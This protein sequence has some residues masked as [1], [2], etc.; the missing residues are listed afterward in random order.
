[1][2]MLRRILRGPTVPMLLIMTAVVLMLALPAKPARACWNTV[3]QE[4]F[5]QVAGPNGYVW[6]FQ[7]PAYSGRWWQRN[8]TLPYYCWGH[9]D[10]YYSTTMCPL[11]VQALWCV[12]GPLAMDP[13][14]D[15]YPPNYQGYCIYGPFSL[16][17]AEKAFVSFSLYNQSEPNGDS[18]FWGASNSASLSTANMRWSGGFSGSTTTT[19]E[20]RDMDLSNLRSMQNGDSVSMLGQPTVYVWWFF[21]ANSNANLNKVGAFIDNI[22]IRWDDGG[23]DVQAWS[24]TLLRADTVVVY[25]PRIGDTLIAQCE[26]GT[27]DG[28]LDDYPPFRLKAMLDDT[29][30]LYDTLITG[31]WSGMSGSFFTNPWVLAG[32]G[33]HVVRLTVDYLDSVVEVNTTNNV[34]QTAYTLAP[35]NDPPVF[36][37]LA[38]GNDTLY[39]DSQA[40]LR[41]ECSDSLEV[42]Q[43][44]L[45]RDIDTMG[46]SGLSLP[47]NPRTE[48]D[49]PDSLVLSTQTMS[50]GTIFYPVA[51]VTDAANENCYYV[52]APV[53]ICRPCPQDVP[54]IPILSPEGFFLSQNYP[55]PFNPVTE[56][57][58]GLNTGGN[59]TLRVFDLLGR[60]VA[61]P[62]NG[63]REPG[64]YTLTFN[65]RDLPAGL[66]F[67]TLTSP[68]GTVSRKMMLLK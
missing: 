64:A 44:R 11:S 27:C 58:Y 24:I 68:E 8:P 61:T 3:L 17:A 40:I 7:S 2:Q 66:Y 39:A 4:C 43:I 34:A 22:T 49:G 57:R 59:V 12:G 29:L 36:R 9:Q 37:W 31:A 21:K 35:I 33:D 25:N 19:F 65:G 1:M 20:S 45:Y 18:I 50:P 56:I 32:P 16:A 42:A 38:P 54:G 26:W 23:M 48:H 14:Y 55:N 52:A 5:D 15:F 60:A 63:F 46:C 13:R 62:V 67:Y 28:G 47:G 10:Y 6:P 30:V 51:V 53:K 41:W